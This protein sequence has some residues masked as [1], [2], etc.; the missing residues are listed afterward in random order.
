MREDG[1]VA[2]ESA[3]L[4]AVPELA[5]WTDGWR[6][7]SRDEKGLSLA[8]QVPPHITVLVPWASP[9]DPAARERLVGV[10]AALEPVEVGFESAGLFPNG[11]VYLKPSPD[12]TPMLRAVAAAFPEYPAYG[13]TIPDPHPHLTL[14]I[15]GGAEVLAEVEA[16]LASEPALPRVL[17]DHL[18]VYAPGDDDVWRERDRVRLGR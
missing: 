17:V 3:V 9:D 2:W 13:G 6:S 16:A 5:A 18:H 11:T 8:A 1:S 15:A 10:A 7:A 12:L 4:V 14:S